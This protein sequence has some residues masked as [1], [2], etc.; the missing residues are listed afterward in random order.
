VDIEVVGDVYKM[1]LLDIPLVHL[2]YM[3]K[4]GLGVSSLEVAK[5]KK[6]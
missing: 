4:I 1:I 3:V 2:T 6:I 5:I